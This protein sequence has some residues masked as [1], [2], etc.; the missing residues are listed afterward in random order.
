MEDVEMTYDQPVENLDYASERPK[1]ARECLQSA[2]ELYTKAEDQATPRDERA[3]LLAEAV[4]EATRAL[5][6][7]GDEKKIQ[8]RANTLLALCHERQ[9]KYAT[10]YFEWGAAK[11]QLGAE[12]PQKG[13]HSMMFCF[14]KI[15]PCTSNK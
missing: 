13:E 14:G 12:W 15:H 9:D 10:A 7:A 6:R 5:Q 1:S 3:K 2:G 11:E 8:G 4:D